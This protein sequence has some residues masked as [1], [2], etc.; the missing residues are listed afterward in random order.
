MGGLGS[1]WRGPA[2]FVFAIPE[3][4]DPAEVGP[5]L[6]G[7]ITVYAPL[8]DNGCGPGKSV[9]IVGIGGLG[10]F[11]VL[12][13]KALGADRVV[14]LSR[15]SDKREDVLALGADEL[16]ATEEDEKWAEKNTDS[17]DLIISTVSPHPKV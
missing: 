8:K 2:R 4:M 6:C 13:A 12:F 17:L 15:K 3:G 1:Y 7:G 16:I 9:G 10:H 5:M 14:A 11:G